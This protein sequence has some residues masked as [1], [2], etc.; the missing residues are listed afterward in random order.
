MRRTYQYQHRV[1]KTDWGWVGIL[2]S[3][4]GLRRTTLP[5]LT[6][7]AAIDRLGFEINQSIELKA[8][9]PGFEEWL[10]NFTKGQYYRPE[11]KLD[12]QDVP[13]FYKSVWEACREI[14]IGDTRSYAWVARASGRPKAVRAVG[15]A[16]AKNKLPLVVPCHRVIGSNGGLHGFA[17]GL[18][19]KRW[20][21]RFESGIS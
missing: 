16:M 6:S 10:H 17:G 1:L 11:I 19:L 8:I 18:S 20:L 15:Q 9:F 5:Q 3:D 12:L 4:L 21:L 7:S 2:G 14:P 13:P